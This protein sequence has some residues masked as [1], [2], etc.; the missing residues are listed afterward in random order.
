MPGKCT[1]LRYQVSYYNYEKKK[2]MKGS[3]FTTLKHA[4]KFLDMHYESAK[5][6]YNEKANKYGKYLKIEKLKNE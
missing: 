3:K 5:N 2:W 1:K 6:L 4:A